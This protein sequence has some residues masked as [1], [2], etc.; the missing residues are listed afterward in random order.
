MTKKP[1]LIIANLTGCTGCVISILDLHEEII[2]LLNKVDLI[3]CP[4]ILD[5]KEIPKCDIALIDGTIGNEHDIEIAKEVEK[6]AGKVIALGSCACFGGI[7]GLRNFF[8]KE[9]T[10][11][12]AY[13]T[14]LTNDSKVIPTEV[15]QLTDHIEVLQDVIKVCLLYTS[16]S[17]RDR[18]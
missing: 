10:L 14:T 1:T 15:P 2:E 9:E 4:T 18:S 11:E 12:Y 6:K 3:Y 16:P 17:P 7:T 8:T 5:I 13:N